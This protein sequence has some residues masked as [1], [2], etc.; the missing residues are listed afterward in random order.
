MKRYLA[1]AA[2]ILLGWSGLA[3]AA[4]FN[5]DGTNEIGIFRPSSGLWAV[6][7]VTR[8]YFGTTGDTPLPG[9][10]DG[11]GTV[12]IAL[13][14]PGTGLWAVKG[15]TRAYFGASGDTPL[16]GI[17]G[18]GEG[19]TP[20]AYGMVWQGGDI[21]WG[22]GNFTV[23]WNSSTGADYYEIL[24]EGV[25]FSFNTHLALATP[26]MNQPRIIHVD[27]NDGKLLIYA[28]DLAGTKQPT[29]FQFFIYGQ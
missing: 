28:F 22:S 14:R 18:N 27:A 23:E 21:N 20:L 7:G 5:G 1:A 17:G 25:F 8:T 24:V 10:Y 16:P 6:R 11:D 29:G 12:D 9:D 15:L 19:W 3:L 26:V 2:A 4:D 13:F